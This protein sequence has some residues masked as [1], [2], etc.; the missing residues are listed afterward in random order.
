MPS[1]GLHSWQ[2]TRWLKLRSVNST[3]ALSDNSLRRAV[4][5]TAITKNKRFKPA[6]FATSADWRHDSRAEKGGYELVEDAAL[7]HSTYSASVTAWEGESPGPRRQG[8]Y[9]TNRRAPTSKHQ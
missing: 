4:E 3:T 1:N 5:A 7:C 6:V 2:A 9:E 8:R